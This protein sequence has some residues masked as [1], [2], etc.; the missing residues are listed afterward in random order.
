MLPGLG[1]HG[2]AAASA[3]PASPAAGDRAHRARRGRRP[4]RRP[5]QR[6]RRLPGQAVR[7]RRARRPN[8]CSAAPAS[9]GARRRSN[10]RRC[11]IDLLS[12]QVRSTG[13]AGAAL[14]HRVRA[15]RL[16]RP[17]P[18][19]CALA[20]GD[21]A[22]RLGLQPRSGHQRASR[23]TS[24]TCG[25]SCGR[26]SRR[27]PIVT[28]SGR[29]ATGSTRRRARTRTPAETAAPPQAEP[30]RESARAAH[31]RSGTRRAD[32]DRD[33]VR[34]RLQRDRLPAAGPDRSLDPRQRSAACASDDPAAGRLIARAPRQ[35]ASVC[36]L[37]ALHATQ[38]CCCS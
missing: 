36:G 24:A 5:R 34:D 18:P 13:D 33:H 12:R 31:M 10:R 1:G 35:G 17:Q 38:R 20:R 15:A 29:S 6:S 37:P 7:G 19:A 8:P 26:P 3:R 23:C 16:P 25:A 21:P 28:V 32:G 22:R 14:E 27:A 2:G 30:P 9:G 11:S 4:H